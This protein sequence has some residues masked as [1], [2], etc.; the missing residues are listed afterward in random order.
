M[1]KII[2][3]FFFILELPQKKKLT[4]LL[5]LSFVAGLLEMFGLSLFIPVIISLNK[6]D[7][8]PK[9]FL[10]NNLF[11]YFYNFTKFFNNE[12]FFFLILLGIF[13]LFKTI[14]LSYFSKVSSRFSSN[15]HQNLSSRI[16]RNYLYQDYDFYLSRSSSQL[17][18]NVTDEI[19]I[20]VNRF[21]ASFII[22]VNESLIFLSI[23]FLLLLVSSVTFI[24]AVI[25]FISFLIIFN[26]I[27]QKLLK[28]W[29][30][31]RQGHQIALIKYVQEG[32]KNIKDIK[33]NRIE[34]KFFN[35]FTNELRET[36][37][38]N[39]NINFLSL[40]PKY[41]VEFVSIIIFVFIFWIL[42]LL[43]FSN[44]RIIIIVTIF[45]VAAVKL[46]P[47]I[48]R[49]LNA[50]IQIKYSVPAIQTVYK[51]IY[52]KNNYRKKNLSGIRK[53]IIIKNNLVIQN[54]NFKYKN[55]NQYLFRDINL[56]IPFGKTIAILGDSGSGKTTFVDLI[57]GLI[58]PTKGNILVNNINI[59]DNLISWLDNISYVQ[60]FSY[61]TQDSIKANIALGS[62]KNIIDVN[63]V[64]YC[65]GAVRLAG[66]V[67]NMSKGINS[68]LS[69]LANNLS[70]GQ[71]QRL[72]IARALYKNPDILIL[73]E[74]T[75]SL[76]EKTESK[77]IKNIIN[78]MKD[79]TIFIITHKKSLLKYCDFIIDINKSKI[80]IRNN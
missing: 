25:L 24:L 6:F 14:S 18:Q 33:V 62:N 65:L 72:S 42:H 54:L 26:F 45:G 56:K 71:K 79:K 77:L 32:I 30:V 49:I 41:Y 76:D 19:S 68:E 13:F 48:N 1:I 51:E 22:L 21:F 23:S 40:I 47:S 73:D 10:K 66:F 46:L 55:S 36:A 9:I 17:I 3:K 29:S 16:F 64:N 59:F 35:Y 69:E 11:E 37:K 20:L 28:V 57:L 75:N 12:F 15:L 80:K 44:Q 60:Q 58:K 43:N 39:E 4:L 34:E 50:M 27:T 8:D 74:S 31:K 2:S 5:L 61:F 63:R 38:I 52:L 70:G 78:L 53:D 7:S 67:N